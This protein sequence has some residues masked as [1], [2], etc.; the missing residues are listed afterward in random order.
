LF[1]IA[2][3]TLV[4]SGTI[5]GDAVATSTRPAPSLPDTTFDRAYVI[6]IEGTIT[7]IT[8]DSLKRRVDSIRDQNPRLLIIELD[9]PGG[10]LGAALDICN[11]LKALRDEGIHVYTWVHDEAYSAGTIIGLA[12]DGIVMSSQATIGD[13]QPIMLTPGGAMPIDEDLGAK[14]TSPL[15]AELRDS[16]RRDGYDWDMVMALIDPA[17]EIYWVENTDT[18]ERDFVTKEERDRLFGWTADESN[19]GSGLLGVFQG[20]KGEKHEESLTEWRYVTSTPAIDGPVRQP[21]VEGRKELLTMRTPEA[22]AYGFCLASVS[23]EAQLGETFHIDG[24]IERLENTWLESAIEWMASPMVRAVLFLLVLVGAYVEFQ[25]PGFGLGGGVAIVALVLFLG[26]PYLA[27]YVV[28]WEIVA[29]LLG[30]ALLAVEIFVIPG[31]GIA[32]ISGIILLLVGL[33]AS[34]APPEPIPSPGWLPSLPATYDYLR[35][36]L[37]SLAGGLVGGIAAMVLLAKYM[38]RL[39][40]AGRLIAPN[41]VHDAIQIDD[42]Y[43]GIAKVGDIGRSESDLRPAGKARFGATLVDVVSQGEFIARRTRVEVVER[44]GNRVVVR[45]V[46]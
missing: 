11:L 38:P 41:P 43:D 35:R 19:G 14:A 29:I 2:L 45:R 13:C 12:T 27:G 31:F 6:P 16:A 21:V 40:V 24:P 26:A 46:D 20:K 8:H 34:Y 28:T 1:G 30:L 36:G 10:S 25:T 4:A 32:G 33:V 18:G 15:K 9:T 7:D 42:P 44:H 39:P 37:Y 22:I 5:R 17:L 23:N 3:I